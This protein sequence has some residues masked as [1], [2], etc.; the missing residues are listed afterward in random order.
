[1]ELIYQKNQKLKS[2]GFLFII[3]KESILN[4]LFLKYVMD[5]YKSTDFVGIVKDDMKFDK[6]NDDHMLLTKSFNVIYKTKLSSNFHIFAEYM[7]STDHKIITYFFDNFVRIPKTSDITKKMILEIDPVYKD[8]QIMNNSIKKT[9]LKYFHPLK[10]TYFKMK[11]GVKDSKQRN[12]LFETMKKL[13]I[14]TFDEL[15]LI[16][17]TKISSID[18]NN[19]DY[20]NSF[21]KNDDREALYKK[22]KKLV[23]IEKDKFTYINKNHNK[24]LIMTYGYVRDPKKSYENVV[25]RIDEKIKKLKDKM[26]KSG[27]GKTIKN[28]FCPCTIINGKKNRSN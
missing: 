17:K 16:S 26:K 23:N 5:K 14:N 4:M 21:I 6:R 7:K 28:K 27:K 19:S 2:R 18:N 15:I 11:I 12:K 8:L 22:Y 20:S 9:I 3:D 10:N 25:K 13:S 24:D 1:M